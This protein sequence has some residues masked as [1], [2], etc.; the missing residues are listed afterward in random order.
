MV[1]M[2]NGSYP[3]PRGVA[4]WRRAPARHPTQGKP[5]P[6]AAPVAKPRQSPSGRSGKEPKHH[7]TAAAPLQFAPHVQKNPAAVGR[8]AG[9]PRARTSRPTNTTTEEPK[10]SD[11]VTRCTN[12]KKNHYLSGNRRFHTS[13]YRRRPYCVI[14]FCRSSKIFKPKRKFSKFRVSCCSCFASKNSKN[15]GTGPKSDTQYG[16]RR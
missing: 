15:I 5:R 3:P 10:A 13:I 4:V 12:H 2:V 9:P 11:A 8:L 6:R 7:R 1:A 14:T 16:R